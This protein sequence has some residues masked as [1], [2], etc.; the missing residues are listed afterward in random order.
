MISVAT[1]VHPGCAVA[2]RSHPNL[3]G[4][5]STSSLIRAHTIR[6]PKAQYRARGRRHSFR[7]RLQLSTCNAQTGA[8]RPW[9]LALLR[10]FVLLATTLNLTAQTNIIAARRPNIPEMVEADGTLRLDFGD[11][12]LVL[13]RGLQPSLLRTASGVLIVQAQIPEKP[14]PSAR[15][16]YPSAL[17][18]RISRDDGKT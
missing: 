10:L 17:E 3:V 2:H 18:T 11:E 7:R 12:I 15:M 5:T 6:K 8:R 16:H 1:S 14:F 13:P 4:T 9:S